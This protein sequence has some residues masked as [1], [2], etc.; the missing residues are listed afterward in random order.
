MPL[1]EKKE[2]RIT[3]LLLTVAV[4]VTRL[5]FISRMLYEF[6]SIDF[7]VATF[8]FSI[9]QVTPHFPGYVLHILF[10][11]FIL[12]F[13][14]DVNLVFVWISVLLSIGSVLFLWR[15]G[16]S[17]R[18]ERVGVIA[19]LLWLFTPI[20]WFYGEVATSYVYEAFFASAFLYFGIFLLREPNRKWLVY[21]LFI[22]LSLATGSRQSSVVFFL[23]CIIYVL[24]KTSQPIRVWGI[25]L[26]FFFIVT[27]SWVGILFYLSGGASQYFAQAGKETVYRSQSIFFG[28]SFNAHSIVVAKVV[29]YLSI[30]I[31]DQGFISFFPEGHPKL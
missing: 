29:L 1:G 26:L 2:R 11:K 14:S 7:A 10:A 21:F 5:P 16:V 24:W 19:A 28:N 18:G 13:I 17:L 25:G 6:D 31:Q 4:L 9:E 27:S 15:A 20:F 30:A 8:R 22:A 12:L 23:P 3:G